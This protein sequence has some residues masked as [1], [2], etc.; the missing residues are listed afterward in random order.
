MEEALR[1]VKIKIGKGNY[2]LQTALDEESV[3]RVS[4]LIAEITSKITEYTTKEEILALVCMT[5]G[6]RLEKTALRLK[7]LAE[8]MDKLK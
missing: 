8:T 5:L 1:E 2:T 4:E 6:W 3:E 7:T